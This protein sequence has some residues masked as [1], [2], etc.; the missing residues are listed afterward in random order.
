V[1]GSEILSG[2]DSETA[3]KIDSVQSLGDEPL[4]FTPSLLA[5]AYGLLREREV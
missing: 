1:Q 5:I 4:R 3:K 2:P